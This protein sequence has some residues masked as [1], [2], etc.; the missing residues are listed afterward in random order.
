[1][2]SL[3]AKARGPIGSK[4]LRKITVQSLT[5]HYDKQ[6]DFSNWN[7]TKNAEFTELVYKQQQ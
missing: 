7:M 2:Q 5:D 4:H 6:G 3:S 1:M